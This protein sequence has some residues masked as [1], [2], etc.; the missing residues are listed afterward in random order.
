[1]SAPKLIELCIAN[2]LISQDMTILDVP[3]SII[4][5]KNQFN[6]HNIAGVD[7][8]KIVKIH[9]LNPNDPPSISAAYLP[10]TNR[11]PLK[12][13]QLCTIEEKT[14]EIALACSIDIII[15]NAVVD[16]IQIPIADDSTLK[17]ENFPILDLRWK[18]FLNWYAGDEEINLIPGKGIPTLQRVLFSE[19]LEIRC[20]IYDNYIINSLKERD[21]DIPM[22]YLNQAITDEYKLQFTS[23]IQ[24]NK[25]DLDSDIILFY[26]DL[27]NLYEEVVGT[28]SGC[29]LRKGLLCKHLNIILSSRRISIMKYLW[30]PGASRY[31]NQYF[32]PRM[33]LITP[34]FDL[35]PHRIKLFSSQNNNNSYTFEE[36]LKWY[37]IKDLEKDDNL[38]FK[39]EEKG[40][41]M[42]A[43]YEWMAKEEE[44]QTETRLLM[45][46]EDLDGHIRKQINLKIEE[47]L[48]QRDEN[49]KSM[50]E[51]NRENEPEKE[52]NFQFNHTLPG[53]YWYLFENQEY[54]FGSGI[55]NGDEIED[56]RLEELKRAREA[57][58]AAANFENY[59]QE[60]KLRRE[61]EELKRLQRE[62]QDRRLAEV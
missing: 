16:G 13:W 44:R 60:E 62:E 33:N 2:Q 7:I 57:Q 22:I 52:F 4:G 10:G 17:S 36:I 39:A 31:N 14:L 29:S 11:K 43:Y 18:K 28:F 35:P 21:Y 12:A 37:T 8:F 54:K 45:C 19:I 15:M 27:I 41:K 51:T 32:F 58:I 46:Q 50:I 42:R 40:A 48:K 61:M 1:M 6:Y 49:I 20:I 56:M 30:P 53:E 23:I 47:R 3:T 34:K 5:S 38:M 55:H 9:T 59:L 25:F 24:Q 26:Q